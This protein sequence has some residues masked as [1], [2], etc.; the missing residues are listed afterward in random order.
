[1]P[2][3]EPSEAS[4]AKRVLWW[5]HVGWGCG[6]LKLHPPASDVTTRRVTSRRMSSSICVAHTTIP[7][8]QP[9]CREL[10][11]SKIRS[12][13]SNPVSL[14]RPSLECNGASPLFLPIATPEAGLGEVERVALVPCSPR[15]HEVLLKEGLQ[16]APDTSSDTRPPL[17]KGLA[18][19]AHQRDVVGCSSS[20]ARWLLSFTSFCPEA[21]QP[22][23]AAAEDLGE[24]RSLCFRQGWLHPPRSRG[25]G[26]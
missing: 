6:G 10:G 20:A 1:M 3:G 13:R 7:T 5:R 24:V 4:E 11:G 25:L 15:H 17:L 23:T 16:S 12:T 22:D 26:E 8:I 14:L 19:Q 21:P 18:F 9:C 2:L